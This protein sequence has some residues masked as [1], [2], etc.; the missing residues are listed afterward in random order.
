MLIQHFDS[1]QDLYIFLPIQNCNYIISIPN[2]GRYVSVSCQDH[3]AKEA[4]R[5][6]QNDD[7][8]VLAMSQVQVSSL[9]YQESNQK[10]IIFPTMPLAFAH[11]GS[12]SK[13]IPNLPCFCLPL[14][15][16]IQKGDVSIKT[17]FIKM[18]LLTLYSYFMLNSSQYRIFQLHFY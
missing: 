12:S 1:A 14:P 3:H 2:I 8:C 6:Y 16:N 18:K 4:R 5:W 7:H 9:P 13:Y 10:H 17:L 11:F 15:N